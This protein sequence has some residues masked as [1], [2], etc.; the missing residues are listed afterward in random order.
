M[1][2]SLAEEVSQ[3][4]SEVAVA[5]TWKRR[6]CDIYLAAVSLAE[7]VSLG[8][9]EVVVAMTWKRRQGDIYQTGSCDSTL[10]RYSRSVKTKQLWREGMRLVER[11]VTWR[12]ATQVGGAYRAVYSNCF[13]D[14]TA[15]G[16]M[17]AVVAA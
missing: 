16:R 11:G 17:Q 5:V 6:R 15:S 1:A 2:V 4:F 9:S 12:C 14:G 13:T 10:R 7:E 8:L 3:G